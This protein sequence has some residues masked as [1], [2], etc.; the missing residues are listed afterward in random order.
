MYDADTGHLLAQA[1]AKYVPLALNM[2]LTQGHQYVLAV[3]PYSDG[4]LGEYALEVSVSA[5]PN[6]QA[7]GSFAQP[8][9]HAGSASQTPGSPQAIQLNTLYNGNLTLTGDW[10]SLTQP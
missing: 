2:V 6:G 1:F 8:A 5:F 4:T 10:Y 7:P 3:Q 9:S